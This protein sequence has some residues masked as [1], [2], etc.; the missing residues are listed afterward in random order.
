VL[1]IVLV[2]VTPFEAKIDLVAVPVVAEAEAVVNEVDEELCPF[3][4]VKSA[5]GSVPFEF[6]TTSWKGPFWLKSVV[7]SGLHLESPSAGRMSVN[8]SG[9]IWTVFHVEATYQ[10]T[11]KPKCQA[12]LLSYP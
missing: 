3:T 10:P 8:T 1:V 2:E 4:K 11:R 5:E 9:P 12:D 6:V 7:R